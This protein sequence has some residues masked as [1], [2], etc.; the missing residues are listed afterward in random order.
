MQENNSQVISRTCNHLDSINRENNVICLWCANSR[1][2]LETTYR[3]ESLESI[4]F[5]SKP[6]LYIVLLFAISLL[7]VTGL[8]THAVIVTNDYISTLILTKKIT[9]QGT[10][11]PKIQIF[12]TI[13]LICSAIVSGYLC[14]SKDYSNKVRG[15]T[16]IVIDFVCVCAFNL[17]IIFDQ[18]INKYQ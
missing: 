6:K 18:W 9:D 4:N 2:K 15:W 7:L 3:E 8:Y 16:I 10:L 11:F 13:G 14:F 12:S 1:L 5:S 17:L